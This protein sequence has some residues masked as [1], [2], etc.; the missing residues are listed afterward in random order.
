MIM[1]RYFLVYRIKNIDN[2]KSYIGCHRTYNMNDSYMGSGILI[3]NAIKKHGIEKFKKE[4]LFVFENEN[5]MLKKEI[6]LISLEKP[7]YNLHEG[8]LGGWDYMNKSGRN[9]SGKRV[10][11]SRDIY[12]KKARSVLNDM[13]KKDPEFSRKIARK[14]GQTR[15]ILISKGLL[16][17]SFKGK[18]HSIESKIKMSESA[19]LRGSNTT[20]KKHSEETKEKI[21]QS[22][23]RRRISNG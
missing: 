1:K 17:P 15:K 8:G 16:N 10:Q 4:I 11:L 14:S 2:L 5:E 12:V 20:G 13:I 9:N 7:D 3:K 19:K 23:L 21:R 6:E 22:L 18:K